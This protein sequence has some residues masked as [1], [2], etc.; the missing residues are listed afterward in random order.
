ME[1]L[2]KIKITAIELHE[3]LL[4]FLNVGFTR[5]EAFELVTLCVGTEDD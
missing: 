1:E 2:P 5:E 4:A 3:Q